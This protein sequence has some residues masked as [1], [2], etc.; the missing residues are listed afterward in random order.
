M[1]LRSW[2]DRT[3][4]PLSN[5]YDWYI[6]GSLSLAIKEL[7]GREPEWFLSDVRDPDRAGLVAAEDALRRDYHVRL[8]NRKWIEGMMKEGYA[9]AD[10]IA[11][12]VSNTMGWA[13]M[14]DGSVSDDV[15]SEIAAVYVKDKYGLSLRQWFEAENPYAFQDMS[16]VMLESSRKGY[17]KAEPGLLRQRR[18]GIRAVR[19]PPRRR[20]RTPR[21]RQPE[22]ETI[23]R[24][25]APVRQIGGNRP[26]GGPISR[27]NPS[28]AACTGRGVNLRHGPGTWPRTRGRKQT[29]VGAIFCQDA[30]LR[31][32]EIRP[33]TIRGQRRR[34]NPG[35][36]P[37]H[38]PQR[39]KIG[40]GGDSQRRRR[41]GRPQM[42][43]GGD[44]GD[45]TAA[46][47]GRIPLSKGDAMSDFLVEILYVIASS[48]LLPVL[49]VLVAFM[50]G[51]LLTLG[52][53]ARELVERRRTM[54]AWR[55]FLADLRNGKV[56]PE[57]FYAL[58]LSGYVERFRRETVAT[59]TEPA[60]CEEV[61][62]RLG[63]RRCPPLGPPLA[64][65][66]RRPHA[67][68][69]RN[70]DP[71]GPSPDRTGRRPTWTS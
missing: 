22:N 13:I 21:R 24:R 15:W 67:W 44:C 45:R 47:G 19:D 12:H 14:R 52:G 63:N 34:R 48:L 49:L 50:A 25:N 41:S 70:V 59:A 16:E 51:T 2:S 53:L 62:G 57:E 18:R 28:A 31:G 66:P 30:G 17:W 3:R 68:P 33:R 6:G 10:Q 39:Q 69:G 56:G 23:R 61:P 71:A 43:A 38:P 65:H 54:A 37:N 55:R 11:V 58:P 26:T 9:G 20:G 29:C 64:G 4:S 35:G 27:S 1:L 42:A 36:D 60:G 8:F 46:V 32:G 40:A 7:T 5:K